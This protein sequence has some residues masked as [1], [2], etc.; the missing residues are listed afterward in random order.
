M[1][2]FYCH[3][4]ESQYYERQS[5]HDLLLTLADAGDEERDELLERFK[6]M[7]EGRT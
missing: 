2:G 6:A 4:C 5:L 1:M 7:L 3:G